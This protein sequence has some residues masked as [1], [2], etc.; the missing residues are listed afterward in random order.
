MTIVEQVKDAIKQG[1]QTFANDPDFA[2][3]QKFYEDMQRK[4]LVRKQGYSLPQL[5][6][7]GRTIY[8]RI[9]TA[10]PQAWQG[11]RI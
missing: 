4:G 1:E 3:L 6:T 7:V 9:N 5:D 8:H 10:D 2:Q 11:R